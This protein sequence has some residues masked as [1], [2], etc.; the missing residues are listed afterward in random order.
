MPPEIE[1]V[2]WSVLPG[3]PLSVTSTANVQSAPF[4]VQ[5]PLNVAVLPAITRVVKVKLWTFAPLA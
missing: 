4:L 5:V 1:M 3:S 2:N